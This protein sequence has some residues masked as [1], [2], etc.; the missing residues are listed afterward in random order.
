[1]T[2]IFIHFAFSQEL[3]VFQKGHAKFHLFT[4]MYFFFPPPGYSLPPSVF[5]FLP[6]L[7]IVEQGHDT[8]QEGRDLRSESSSIPI[9]N[10]TRN[11]YEV[12]KLDVLEMQKIDMGL[13]SSQFWSFWALESCDVEGGMKKKNLLKAK[14]AWIRLA[15]NVCHG[16]L[17]LC[18]LW[19]VEMGGGYGQISLGHKAKK[20]GT[21]LDS[22]EAH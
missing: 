16:T 21:F 22:P 3:A 12:W 15:W 1:M 14:I 17:A 13:E 9:T 18:L 7:V 6:P 20:W 10:V 19:W 11:V 5:F 4:E 8:I 2:L